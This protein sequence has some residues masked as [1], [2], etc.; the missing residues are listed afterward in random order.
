MYNIDDIEKTI[1]TM[2]N[3]AKALMAGADALENSL[4]PIKAAQA[5]VDM[6]NKATGNMLEFWT[7]KSA[8]TKPIA[9]FILYDDKPK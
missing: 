1:A 9:P 5:S 3:Q 8:L 4:V 6:W 7:G 2:R